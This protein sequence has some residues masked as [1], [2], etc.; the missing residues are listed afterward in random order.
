MRERKRERERWWVL[1]E[2]GG[3]ECHFKDACAWE[4]VDLIKPPNPVQKWQF[5]HVVF[6]AKN[7]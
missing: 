7:Y 4:S 6:F 3:C 1:R 2:G 5:L